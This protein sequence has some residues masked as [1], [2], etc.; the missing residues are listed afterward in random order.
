MFLYLYTGTD[1]TFGFFCT[2]CVYI[3]NTIDTLKTLHE[4]VSPSLALFLTNSGSDES[5]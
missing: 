4:T 5:L 3:S 2:Y 1:T